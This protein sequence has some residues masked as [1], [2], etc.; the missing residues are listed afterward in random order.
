MINFVAVR[1]HHIFP[2][3]R[4]GIERWLKNRNLRLYY[5][6]TLLNSGLIQQ[7]INASF[8]QPALI[9]LSRQ[10]IADKAVSIYGFM[11]SE[12]CRDETKMRHTLFAWGKLP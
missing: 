1:M 9:A 7:Q 6:S 4:T 12:I 8:F 5:V 2:S 10:M 3:M 11:E